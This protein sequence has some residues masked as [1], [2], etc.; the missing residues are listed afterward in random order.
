MRLEGSMRRCMPWPT[1][2]LK[3]AELC[4]CW[5]RRSF[6]RTRVRRLG[7]GD[8]AAGDTFDNLRCVVRECEKRGAGFG[9]DFSP[10]NEIA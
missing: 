2:I 1:T 5:H 4:G 10:N 7:Y 3:Y 9:H 6:G 8:D